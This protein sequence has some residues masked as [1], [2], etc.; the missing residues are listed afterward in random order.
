MAGLSTAVLVLIGLLPG[1]L[2]V[3]T[4]ERWAGRFGIGL[5][6]RA[7]RFIGVSAVILSIVAGPLYWVYMNYWDAFINRQVLP[8]WFWG[9]PILYTVVPVAAGSAL[10]FGWKKNW[11]WARVLIGRDRA[12]RAWDHLFQDCPVGG[13]RLKMKSGTWLGGVYAEA[14]DGGRPFASG[15]PEPQELYLP[16]V[17]ALNPSTGGMLTDDNDEPL[18]LDM[19][20]LVRWDEIEFL[21]FI[22]PSEDANEQ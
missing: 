3:W 10:G 5:R 16:R 18:V 21:E 14:S 8:W 6:D 20:I 9:F 13:I 12:P 19:G 1:A 22:K 7:L 15:Y 11:V 2:F 4:F 17:V